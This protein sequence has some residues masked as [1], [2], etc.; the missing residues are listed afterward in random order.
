[1]LTKNEGRRIA[2]N[3]AK[4]PEAFAANLDRKRAISR[5]IFPHSVKRPRYGIPLL[6]AAMVQATESTMPDKV[7]LGIFMAVMIALVVCGRVLT[8]KPP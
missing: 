4:L 5:W 8:R 2:V 7:A 6:Y 3:I 1:L